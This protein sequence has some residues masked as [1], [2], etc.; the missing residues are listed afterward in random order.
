MAVGHATVE[1]CHARLQASGH[2]LDDYTTPASA[3]DVRDLMRA[4]DAAWG[5]A[6]G[7]AHWNLYGVSYGT[8]LAMEVQRSHPE[9]VRSAVLDSVYPPDVDSTLAW[10]GLL[11]D[12]VERL[13]T[14]CEADP[15]CHASH[16]HLRQRFPALLERLAR[17][18]L[19]LSLPD[20]GT[21]DPLSVQVNDERLLYVIFD[22]LYQWDA[23]GEL[24]AAIDGL[25]R[26]DSRRL[27]PLVAR[28]A[29]SVLDPSF[30]DAVYLSVECHDAHP[31]DRQRYLKAVHDHPL[32]APYTRAGADHDVCEFWSS[33]RAPDA[34][35][36]PVRSDLPTLLL[37]GEM[38]PVT[39]AAWAE[40]A[41]AGYPNGWLLRFPGIGHSVLDSDEC[42]VTVVRRFLADPSRP[43]QAD[44]MQSLAPVQFA[45]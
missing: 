8:R 29:G 34:F 19:A 20:P 6:P 37:A 4:L 28:H 30:S 36:E 39:P 16:P 7:A 25:W 9:R 43:V 44:C 1:R 40:A 17:R 26:G 11:Q 13:F 18:P 5:H 42:G 41:A 23:I 10:P 22:T 45:P 24:P 27:Q 12:A 35:F 33:G 14:A 15:A 21:G 3:T 32:S 31:F 2:R 38:D